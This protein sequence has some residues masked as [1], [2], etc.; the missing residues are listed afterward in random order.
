MINSGSRNLLTSVVQVI[1]P[2][3]GKLARPEF[4]DIRPRVSTYA[5]DDKFITVSRGM[6]W[7]NLGL[8]RLGNAR[9]WWAIADLSNVVDPFA[10]LQ[11]GRVLRSPSVPRYLF[12]IQA[13]DQTAT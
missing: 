3:T 7:A 13:T 5:P 8:T 9:A 12:Q 4:V 10:E 6:R 1:D 11:T 2:V